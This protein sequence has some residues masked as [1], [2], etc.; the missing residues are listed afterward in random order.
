MSVTVWDIDLNPRQTLTTPQLIQRLRDHARVRLSAMLHGYTFDY[1]L[2]NR[3]RGTEERFLLEPL[4]EIASDDLRL[5][6]IDSWQTDGVVWGQFTYRAA[7]AEAAWRDAWHGTPTAT[8]S[9]IGVETVR[10]AGGGQQG[11]VVRAVR[12]AITDY[13][14]AEHKNKPKRVRG[15]LLFR[16]ETRLW[17]DSGEYRA[18]V[19]LYLRIKEIEELRA[20]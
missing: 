19:P 8:G 17:I 5:Q 7:G 20:F 6:M 9:A 15:T 11:A 13:L 14:R 18:R 4:G 16:D 2:E 3:A 10:A 12:N 1:T